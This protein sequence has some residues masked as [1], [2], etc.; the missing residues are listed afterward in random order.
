MLLRAN[1]RQS[2]GP[3]PWQCIR[4]ISGLH[5][6]VQTNQISLCFPSIKIAKNYLR[7]KIRCWTLAERP[8]VQAIIFIESR[9]MCTIGLKAIYTAS[10]AMYAY[11]PRP[12]RILDALNA[13]PRV[14][15]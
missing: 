3:A 7:A 1:T 9:A 4:S 6:I 13:R 11:R 10:N 8:D 14:E 12:Q 15:G 5:H 2:A